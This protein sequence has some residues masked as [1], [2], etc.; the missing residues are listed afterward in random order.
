VW[1]DGWTDKIKL[2][3]IF[4]NFANAPENKSGYPA[5]DFRLDLWPLAIQNISTINSI[6][7][8]GDRKTLRG[9][10]TLTIHVLHSI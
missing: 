7:M 1:T 6:T 4:L 8:S 2:I 9:S 10:R 5:A 3:A